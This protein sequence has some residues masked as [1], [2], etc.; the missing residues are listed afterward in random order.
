MMTDLDLYKITLSLFDK[1]ITQADLDSDTPSREIRLCRLYKD[2]AQVRAMREFDWSFLTVKL[3]IDYD[4]DVPGRGF[5]HGYALPNGLLKVV[6]AYTKYKYEVAEG[7][8]Y[9]DIGEPDVYGIMA[10]L[11]E[12][13]VPEDFYE[14]IAYALAY[15][16]APMLAPEG[17]MDKVILQKYTWALNGLLVSECY[18]NSL[19]E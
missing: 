3:Q 19:E 14:L 18:N 5:L 6:R 7:R 17:R 10:D 16:I 9:T 4:D 2:L 1:E 8:I 15:L 13:H 12:S 11:P